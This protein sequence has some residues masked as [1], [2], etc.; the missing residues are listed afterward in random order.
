[1]NFFILSCQ[2]QAE[3]L[4]ACGRMDEATQ[5]VLREVGAHPASEKVRIAA[6]D[7]FRGIGDYENSWAQV[8]A[9]LAV[10]PDYVDLI[11]RVVQDLISLHR[12]EEAKV[13]A[14]QLRDR[15]SHSG[16]RSIFA[17]LKKIADCL[18]HSPSL[19]KA[20]ELSRSCVL[21]PDMSSTGF[22]SLEVQPFQYWSQGD[23]PSDVQECSS[24]WNSL[25]TS[26]GLPP[27][28]LFTKET[29]AAWIRAHAPDFEVPFA[30]AYHY[31]I[32]S[33][34]FRLAYFSAGIDC[35]WIDIDMV[36]K[37]DAASILLSALSR[38]SSLLFFREYSPWISNCFLSLENGAFSFNRLLIKVS[39]QTF[40][41]T[42]RILIPGMLRC[43]RLPTIK[44]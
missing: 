37:C 17:S 36:P 3:K 33:N 1:M 44:H 27:I 20:W 41:S 42:R 22:P 43:V 7:F 35:L 15:S 5:L 16:A 4:Y 14:E 31:T 34:V 21:N 26:I 2:A 25:L 23:P 11:V 40:L 39:F 9:A 38:P 24:Q 19:V 29:A 30:S 32:E 18:A 6:S 12:Y 13:F 10:N 8:Q 28:Q